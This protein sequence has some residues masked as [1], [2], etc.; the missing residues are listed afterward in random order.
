MRRARDEGQRER[1]TPPSP[2]TVRSQPPA[3]L[4][5]TPAGRRAARRQ[6]GTAHRGPSS[7]SGSRRPAIGSVP[8]AL[9]PSTPAGQWRH[10]PIGGSG[11]RFQ[12]ARSAWER[13]I[14]RPPR[15]PSPGP[16]AMR[17][18]ER[19]DALAGVGQ[20]DVAPAERR[21]ERVGLHP[22]AVVG[23]VTTHRAP[24]AS[25]DAHRRPRR[26]GV[27][28]DV[29]EQ[30]PDDADDQAV[31]RR[32]AGRR[33]RGR[34]SAS[35]ARARML[36][37]EALDRGARARRATSVTGCRPPITRR[38]SVVASSIDAC[39]APIVSGAGAR[40]RAAPGARTS[41][42]W[43]TSSCRT[44]ATCRCSRS[45][46][47]S[48]W[49]TSRPRWAASRSSAPRL[50][51]ADDGGAEDVGGR[52]AGRSRRRRRSSPAAR[53]RTP[54]TPNG[55]PGP[56][57]GVADR[58]RGRRGRAGAA[59]HVEPVLAS[60]CRSSGRRRRPSSVYPACDARPTRR[61]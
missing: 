37:G 41:R 12:R 22:A 1:R 25:S 51:V 13:W 61:P 16:T 56:G 52:R 8:H 7:S 10:P 58:A 2:T 33:P 42:C 20:P 35:P 5:A 46:A 44:S 39:D 48:A 31:V 55:A 24:A 34:R 57:I 32:P 43:S 14:V 40:R 27:L 23:D 49:A 28:D 50:L 17:A 54:T 3:S 53:D 4:S 15:P 30:L 29:V 6:A 60:A 21:V 26:A 18:A 59:R 9:T 11:G 36:G 38:S 45:A 47:S 19:R